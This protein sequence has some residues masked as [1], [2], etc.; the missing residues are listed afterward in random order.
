VMLFFCDLAKCGDC[1][2]RPL[3]AKSDHLQ[4]R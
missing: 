1:E 4:N 3:T 2:R